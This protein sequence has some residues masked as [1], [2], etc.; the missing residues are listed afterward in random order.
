MRK[1]FIGFSI[2]SILLVALFSILVHPYFAFFYILL[3]PVVLLGIY[4]MLQRRHT[5]MRIYPV[6]G[7]LRY[8]FEDLRPK[9]YQYFI[10]NDF[11]GRPLNRIDRNVVYQRAKNTNDTMPFG[12]QL[13]VYAE[14]YEWISHSINPVNAEEHLSDP[15]V[16]IGNKDCTQP[17]SAS[18]MNISAMS[19]G[20]LSQ[21]AILALNG[22][23]KLGNFYHNTGEGGL[24]DYHLK[25]KGDIVWQIGTG[26]FGARNEDGTFNVDKFKE[27]AHLP[28]VKMIELKLSQGAKPGH[29]GILPAAKNTPEIAKM[30]LVKAGTD[31]LS[32]PFHSAFQNPIGLI[33]FI[34]TLRKASGGKPVGFKICIGIKTEFISI[35]KAMKELDIYPDFITIDGGEGGTG[36]APPEFSD[37]VGMPL[38]DALSFVHDALMG[39]G[40]RKHI[41]LIASGKI[42]NA[43][44]IFRA[45]SL[46]A[47][48]CN[49]AR[50]MML[51]LGCIQALLCNT[52]RCPTGVA[53]QDPS[54]N[55]GL[56][57]GY[58]TDRVAAYHKSTI[59]LFCEMMAACGL[60]DTTGINRRFINRRVFM[61]TVKT[62]EEIYGHVYQNQFIENDIPAEW[63]TVLE[64]AAS[65]K[66]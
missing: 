21:N 52:N 18:I 23:A 3:L 26:Y 34:D 11:D 66:W 27:R 48:L 28:N 56:D 10:E 5:I 29:G 46:G 19:F 14:G 2:I 51:A 20:S 32:P 53:T 30:R 35:C 1:T 22:G 47:D 15:R 13:N 42:H 40:I 9:F 50:G 55:V 37:H 43:F 54:L 6:L 8:V 36:A 44:Y 64:N 65:S 39:F 17:Y 24:S 33:K 12:T 59:K 61:N 60:R 58:K 62:F 25:N 16:V 57:V 31:V 4:D 49:N 45:M 38:E 7:R 63:K 41:K